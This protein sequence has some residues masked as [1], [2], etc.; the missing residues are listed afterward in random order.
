[1]QH[2]QWQIQRSGRWTTGK[3]WAVSTV[4]LTAPISSYLESTAGYNAIFSEIRRE[5]RRAL[6]QQALSDLFDGPFTYAIRIATARP[7]DNKLRYVTLGGKYG[8]KFSIPE[9]PLWNHLSESLNRDQAAA[10][11][12]LFCVFCLE[13]LYDSHLSIIANELSE[14]GA[15][16]Y[17]FWINA[18]RERYEQMLERPKPPIN[19]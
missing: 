6:S 4:K 7:A 8:M 3:K 15:P 11:T 1:M 9:K 5:E 12:A 2:Q 13:E 14:P 16:A 10:E 17:K 18:M 19:F